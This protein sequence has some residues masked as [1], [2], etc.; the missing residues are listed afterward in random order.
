M[1]DRSK[2]IADEISS[3]IPSAVIAKALAIGDKD[4][5]CGVVG[6]TLRDAVVLSN[7]ATHKGVEFWWD[8]ELGY[9]VELNEGELDSASQI[10]VSSLGLRPSDI[11]KRETRL[12]Q[13]VKENIKLKT[14]TPKREIISFKN[15]AL[16][17]ES[18][19]T[20]SLNPKIHCTYGL[21]YNYDRGAE[22]PL[23]MSF[24]EQVLPDIESRMI[25]QEYLGCIFINRRTTKLEKILYLHGGGSNGKG[26]VYETIRGI[27]GRENV[28]EFD[29]SHLAGSSSSSEYAIAKCDGGLLNYCSDASKKEIASDKFKTIVSGEP[30]PARHPYGRPFMAENLPV[31]MANSNELPITSDSTHGYFRRIMPLSFD[32]TISDKNQDTQLHLKMIPEYPGILN[33]ILQGR[34]RF[35]KSGYKFTESKKVAERTRDYEIESNSILG[36]LRENRYY[37]IRA[38]IGHIPTTMGSKKMYQSYSSWCITMGLKAF[39]FN[40][41]G[42]KLKEKGFVCG[43]RTVVEYGVYE[44][45]PFDDYRKIYARGVGDFTLEEYSVM[46]YGRDGDNVVGSVVE[47]IVSKDAPE[48]ISDIFGQ[49]GMD[50]TAGD[51]DECP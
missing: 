40:K 39:S 27:V 35:I 3:H 30:T 8:S 10:L 34:D 48:P 5:R 50:F 6:M 11:F 41:F 14:L 44:L 12:K 25:L 51:E 28:T 33:W 38:Y 22:C 17:V 23:W 20:L 36:Y 47:N 21:P 16:D 32:V 45:P 4:D 37:P 9:W 13:M 24:L 15:C 19:G 7:L 1:T 31:M 18:G 46:L 2:K 42:A 43:R 49:T 29:L 26:V